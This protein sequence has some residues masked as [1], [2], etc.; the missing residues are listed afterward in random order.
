M[1]RGSLL[2]RKAGVRVGLCAPAVV[3]AHAALELGS[4]NT[5]ADGS[6]TVDV[7]SRFAGYSIAVFD[8]A[9][10]LWKALNE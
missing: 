5:A 2:H 9:D 4:Y 7:Q 10:G 6:Q 1:E 3:A 8:A